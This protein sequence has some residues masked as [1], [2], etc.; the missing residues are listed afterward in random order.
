MSELKTQCRTEAMRIEE[1]ALHSSKSHFEASACWGRVHL[2]M[3]IPTAIT[4]A[5]AGVSALK[6]HPTVAAVLALVVAALSALATFLNPSGRA[7]SHLNAG[8]QFLSLRNRTR[9]FRE[10][11]VSSARDEKELKAEIIQLSARRD[12]LNVGSPQV[13]GWAHG[14]AKRGIEAGEA[15]HAVDAKPSSF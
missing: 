10:I 8:N 3:G 15:T 9:V 1:D 14:R 12:E 5:I 4:A 2:A 11:E 13:P 6:A 7:N